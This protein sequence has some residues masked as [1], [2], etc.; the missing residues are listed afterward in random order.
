MYVPGMY[1]DVVFIL[2]YCMNEVQLYGHGIYDVLVY[3]MYNQ[4][5]SKSN[6]QNSLRRYAIPGTIQHGTDAAITELL[7]HT[8]SASAH[9]YLI[10]CGIVCMYQHVVFRFKIR[11]AARYNLRSPSRS[12]NNTPSTP[13]EIDFDRKMRIKS[14]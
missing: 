8:R 2:F 3:T 6:R 4:E 14:V 9:V 11:I 7:R 10:S 12:I 1:F 13:E 5:R